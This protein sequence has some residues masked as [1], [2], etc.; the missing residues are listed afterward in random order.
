MV[1]TKYILILLSSFFVCLFVFGGYHKV[2]N[3]LF[4]E[5]DGDA[6]S[7]RN[8]GK[9]KVMYMRN[10]RT[11]FLSSRRAWDAI[12]SSLILDFTSQIIHNVTEKDE[13]EMLVALDA[14]GFVGLVHYTKQVPKVYP[15][16]HITSL[17]SHYLH[18]H[19]VVT[20]YWL[21]CSRMLFGGASGEAN[22]YIV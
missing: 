14:Q 21:W 20:A 11:R 4:C 17:F 12:S 18:L 9:S 15:H 10:I 13:D 2:C 6:I 22:V 19:D 1:I 3:C 8:V 5:G 7:T 16:S